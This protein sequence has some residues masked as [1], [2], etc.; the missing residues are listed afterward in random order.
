MVWSDLLAN[1]ILIHHHFGTKP[2]N[3]FEAFPKLAPNSAGSEHAQTTFIIIYSLI[4]KVKLGVQKIS[5]WTRDFLLASV[6]PFFSYSKP[7]LWE[8]HEKPLLIEQA[9]DYGRVFKLLGEVLLYRREGIMRWGWCKNS[10]PKLD[11]RKG[12]SITSGC[13]TWFVSP[14]NFVYSK[15]HIISYPK[16]SLFV[17]VGSIWLWLVDKDLLNSHTPP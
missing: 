4:Y 3:H 5:S 17:F 1:P 7:P 14:I 2:A 11:D 8:V 15:N 13:F 9:Y 12:C 10:C 6:I 16:L